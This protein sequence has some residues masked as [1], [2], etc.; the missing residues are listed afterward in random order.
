M[1]EQY[2]SIIAWH[3]SQPETKK[4]LEVRM[5]QFLSINYELTVRIKVQFIFQFVFQRFPNMAKTMSNSSGG[6]FN[7][8]GKAGKGAKNQHLS[9]GMGM[10]PQGIGGIHPGMGMP[11]RPMMQGGQ[12]NMGPMGSMMDPSGMPMDPDNDMSGPSLSGRNF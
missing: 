6:R 11:P 7:A 9:Q 5:R 10:R 4:H 3:E 1:S 12:H 2:P 8:G